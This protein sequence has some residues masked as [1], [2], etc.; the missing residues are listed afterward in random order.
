MESPQRKNNQP[1]ERLISWSLI[2]LFS[3]S[4]IFLVFISTTAF[5]ASELVRMVKSGVTDESIVRMVEIKIP[6]PDGM[7]D[8]LIQ[9]SNGSWH[10]Q[11]DAGSE[12]GR[13]RALAP[14]E[15]KRLLK[16]RRRILPV[17]ETTREN[18]SRLY[19]IEEIEGILDEANHISRAQ[20]LRS[21]LLTVFRELAVE[22]NRY[23]AGEIDDL[24]EREG[25]NLKW[26]SNNRTTIVPLIAYA[27]DVGG[28]LLSA[29]PIAVYTIQNYPAHGPMIGKSIMIGGGLVIL[30]N[31]REAFP[32][33][34][35]LARGAPFRPEQP[36]RFGFLKRVGTRF[37]IM[38][39]TIGCAA[40]LRALGV[41]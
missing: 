2:N 20:E 11:V 31:I 26:V 41:L 9:T 1:N 10:I 22:N 21:L 4:F 39:G 16:V 29:F 12:L 15:I 17:V 3:S 8:Y 18:F 5:S 24:L 28:V 38:T 40:T 32:P 23:G 35:D 25:F 7:L 19:P 36:A 37:G 34:L 27:T 14:K 13:I 33:R 30:N 6:D